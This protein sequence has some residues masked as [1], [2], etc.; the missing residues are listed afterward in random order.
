MQGFLQ[1]LCLTPYV[2]GSD[3]GTRGLSPSP[4]SQGQ[5]CL[6]R[7]DLT[8]LAILKR[9]LHIIGMTA[10]IAAEHDLPLKTE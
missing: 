1:D 2:R 10:Q 3:F 5:H 6:L 8:S 7:Q 4:T 9:A